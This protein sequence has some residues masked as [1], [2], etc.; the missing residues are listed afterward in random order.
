MKK[1]LHVGAGQAHLKLTNN[2][3]KDSGWEEIRFDISPAGK[4][5][6]IGEMS[7]MHMIEDQ[8]MDALYSSHNIEH[9]YPHEVLGTLR[10]FKRVL[11]GDGFCVIR[12]PDIESVCEDALKIGFDQPLYKSP[13]GPITAIDILYGHIASIA[14]GAEYMAHKNGFTLKTMAENLKKAGF[15]MYSGVRRKATRYD[16]QFVAFPNKVSS[17]YARE[18]LKKYTAGL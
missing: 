6:I 1:V 5:D 17:E 16:L 15:G 10:E 18:T 4:P 13:S 7:D 14:R 2:A 8:S 3:F 12:C 11:K 9:V